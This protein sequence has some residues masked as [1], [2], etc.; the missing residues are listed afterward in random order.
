MKKFSIYPAK[1]NTLEAS[2][3]LIVSSLFCCMVGLPVLA[4]IPPSF[5]ESQTPSATAL[6]LDSDVVAKEMSKEQHTGDVK[7]EVFSTAQSAFELSILNSENRKKISGMVEAGAGVG[8]IPEQH[9][10]KAENVNC[11]NA[12]VAINDEISNTTQIGLY[13]QVDTCRVK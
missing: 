12:A 11:E 5:T 4:Q 2:I 7:P 3:S 8:R 6:N 9:W 10:H 1:L 13:A